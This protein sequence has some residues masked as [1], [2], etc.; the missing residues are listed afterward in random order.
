MLIPS[1]SPACQHEPRWFL[2]KGVDNAE[3][4]VKAVAKDVVQSLNDM[5]VAVTYHFDPILNDLTRSSSHQ[6]SNITNNL[7]H[8]LEPCVPVP[9]NAV[10]LFPRRLDGS[11]KPTT[12]NNENAKDL[13]FES[14]LRKLDRVV[15]K[16]S[17]H[18]LKNAPT[19]I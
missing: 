8:K 7:T 15:H 14:L 18:F 10:D 17:R 3:V 12:I 1:P 16:A 5:A 11:Y 9:K 4:N 2:Q 19:S 6:H 13:A